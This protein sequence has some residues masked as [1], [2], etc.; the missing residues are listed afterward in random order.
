MNLARSAPALPGRRTMRIRG[1]A[2]FA[3]CLTACL[4]A[5]AW[6]GELAG[7]TL[8]EQT[9]VEKST[10]MLNGMGA[11]E[12]TWLNIRVY[13]AGLYLEGKSSDADVILRA[14]L[15][16]RIVFVFV[17]S[18]GRK[19]II[20]EWDESLKANVGEDLAALED[21]VATLHSWMPDAVTKG[22][23]MMLTYLPGRGVV[24]EING[25]ARGTI[26]GADFARALFSIWLGARPPNKTLKMGLLGYD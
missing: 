2:A 1:G 13:V 22:D 5:P 8:P 25:E 18:V 26:P 9:S 7:V 15:P 20:K 4:T 3:A 24:V 14:E 6:T 11:R 10:L 23:E 12:V 17:R 19:S 21:R 16:K